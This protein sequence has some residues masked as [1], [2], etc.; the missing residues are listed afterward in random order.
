MKRYKKKSDDAKKTAKEK[1]VELFKQAE[2]V[3]SR[4][5]KAADRCVEKARKTAM[6]IRIKIPP[7][8]KRNFCKHCYKYIVPGINCRVRLSEGKVIYYCLS[9]K[10]FMRFPHKKKK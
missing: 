10:K 2:E 5:S 4:D 7:M 6:K 8:L 9:C 1:I 3:F